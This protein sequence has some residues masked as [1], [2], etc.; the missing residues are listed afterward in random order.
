MASY[1]FIQVFN[2]GLFEDKAECFTDEDAVFKRMQD[3][4][5]DKKK[6]SLYTAECKMDLT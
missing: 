6:F 3:L 2:K 4:L 5:E 1:Y